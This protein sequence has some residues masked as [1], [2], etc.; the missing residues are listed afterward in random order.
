MKRPLVAVL[1]TLA[2]TIG[3][4]PS[5]SATVS[6]HASSMCIVSLSPTATETLYAIGAGPN[7][8]AVDTDSNY[9]T[10]GL[11]KK[12][13][14][15][16]N[17]NAEQIATICPKSS[18]HPSTKPDLVVVAYDANS[19]V[20]RL[21]TLHV[22][23]ILQDA[24]ASLSG[25]YAQILTLG[26]LTGH[27]HVAGLVVGTI[28]KA[29][30]TAVASVPVHPKKRLTYYYELDPTLYTL[31]SSTF[32]GSLLHSLTG[33]DIADAVAKS[34]DYGYPQLSVEYLLSSNP[35]LVFLADTVCCKVNATSFG[36]RPG[37]SALSAVKY[38]HVYGLNDDVAS[39][40]GPRL[41]LLVAQLA[42]AVDAT[43]VDPRP[44]KN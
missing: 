42:H 4:L 33:V 1:A 9:P 40:W 19:I 8:K 22:H 38:R 6:A 27:A 30:A 26:N 7:V 32:V 3:V 43:L 18:S 37:Y 17:P 28:K 16:F 5:A 20:E 21:T 39:R 31:T 44:W 13:L 29:V 14:D 12:R 11:P 35:K 36:A 23:A 34:S 25:A 24:P 41:S 15:P 2:L 10:T